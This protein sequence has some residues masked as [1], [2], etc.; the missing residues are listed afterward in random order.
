MRSLGGGWLFRTGRR[1]A[2]AIGGFFGVPAAHAGP[3]SRAGASGSGL[4]AAP[5][6]TAPLHSPLTSWPTTA[7]C[8]EWRATSTTLRRPLPAGELEQVSQLR[9]HCLDELQR[10]D[11]QA[12][13]RWL[14]E[15]DVANDPT[16]FFRHPSRN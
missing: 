15:R 5:F 13:D 11:Q 3:A 16:P 2:A 12:F 8:R 10:R 9:R 4:V 1:W 6:A 7:V 14:A